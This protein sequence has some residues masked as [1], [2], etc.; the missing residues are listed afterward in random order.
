MLDLRVADVTG[1]ALNALLLALCATVPVDCTAVALGSAVHGEIAQ[2]ALFG[3]TGAGLWFLWALLARSL[4]ER[5]W[6]VEELGVAPAPV[7]ERPEKTL[8]RLP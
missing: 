6:T 3:V 7:P 4:R 1:T 5:P 2:E 8:R